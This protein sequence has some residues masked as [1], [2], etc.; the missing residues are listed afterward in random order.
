MSKRKDRLYS[1]Y[2]YCP[3]CGSKYI[4]IGK[5]KKRFRK[6]KTYIYC[7]ICKKHIK[8]EVKELYG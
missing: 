7:G 8:V 1:E 6:E 5:K 3:I 4:V 2:R